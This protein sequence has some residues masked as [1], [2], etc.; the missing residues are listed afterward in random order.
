[1]HHVRT[2]SEAVWLAFIRRTITTLA[3]HELHT[4]TESKQIQGAPLYP[5]RKNSLILGE[6]AHSSC[7]CAYITSVCVCIISS[8]VVN[9]CL[10][11]KYYEWQCEVHQR[12]C[13]DVMLN[14]DLMKICDLTAAKFILMNIRSS[15]KVA[16]RYVGHPSRGQSYSHA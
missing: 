5:S 4:R 3:H 9:L 11:L 8:L 10:L 6:V 15:K 16:T 7:V 14:G 13:H 12:T 1:M 2:C